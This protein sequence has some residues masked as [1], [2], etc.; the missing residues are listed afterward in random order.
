M[1]D[2]ACGLIDLCARQCDTLSYMLDAP[3]DTLTL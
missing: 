2:D 3:N 1:A